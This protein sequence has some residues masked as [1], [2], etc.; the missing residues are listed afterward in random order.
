MNR[1]RTL[2][3]SLLATTLIFS[4]TTGA[5]AQRWEPLHTP[6]ESTNSWPVTS[7]AM[8][9]RDGDNLVW[10]PSSSVEPLI[11]RGQNEKSV[12]NTKPAVAPDQMDSP[13]DIPNIQLPPIPFDSTSILSAPDIAGLGGSSS[14]FGAKGDVFNGRVL[15][16]DDGILLKSWN[17]W[18]HDLDP[19]I[20]WRG[21]A[22]SVPFKV[23]PLD[24]VIPQ[25]GTLYIN[26]GD[27][28]G[29]FSIGENGIITTDSVVNGGSFSNGPIISGSIVLGDAFGLGGQKHDHYY[30]KDGKRYYMQYTWP[31]KTAPKMEER[32]GTSDIW[33]I[34]SSAAGPKK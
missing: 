23:R 32:V 7:G 11:L 14:A 4:L 1:Y 16:R 33:L 15:G 27:V 19:G 6:I 2:R 20:V 22:D 25:H 5:Y 21:T 24:C 9:V 34:G 13:T 12:L 29:S 28:G 30:L 10:V 3:A 18:D 8:L 26:E 17:G 31:D